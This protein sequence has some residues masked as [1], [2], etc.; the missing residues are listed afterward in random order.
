LFDIVDISFNSSRA[1]DYFEKNKLKKRTISFAFSIRI[2][3]SVK[4]QN[5]R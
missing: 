5:E 1:I 4:R 2:R 3:L